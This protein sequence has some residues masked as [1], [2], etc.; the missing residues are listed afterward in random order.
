[1]KNLQW[2]RQGKRRFSFVLLLQLLS[3]MVWAQS[4]ISGRVTN[5]V[6]AGIPDIS[7]TIRNTNLGTLTDADGNYSLTASLKP[8]TYELVFSGIGYKAISRSVQLG[9]GASETAN[10]QL[11]EDALK[12]D[13]VVI[14]GTS[15]GT[16]R[17]QL[18]SY[19]S[20][21]KYD[22]LTRGATG[23]VLAAL[24]GKTAGAQIIQN[25]G[26]PAGGMS[27]R[28]R[29]ISSISSS[30][31]PLYIVDGIIVNNAT[32]R[33]TNTSG[34]Y[35][36]NNFVGSIGQNRLVDINPADIERI[37]VL[38]GAAAAAIYGSRAN[39]GVVQIF[40]KRGSSGAPVV[41][42]S[43][44]IMVNQLRK[45]IEVNQSPTKFG[46]PTDGAGAQTQD[47]LPYSPPA[48]ATLLTNTTPVTRYDYQDYIFRTALGTD[49]NVSVS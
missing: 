23:D 19:I 37:E 26:D 4:R 35:D 14:T 32:N 48:P 1:M 8:G 43:T 24:Q 44:G 16:T 2:L 27:V 38:N 22:E 12:M 13:E 36:G 31:E 49:N 28:L 34:N 25:S 30:S 7:I 20:T 17:R 3:I 42:F 5:A 29:G 11:V 41:S 18:G 39:A 47:V 6:N 9:N 10:V 40:T 45:K 21:V 33:V 46:G 15:A